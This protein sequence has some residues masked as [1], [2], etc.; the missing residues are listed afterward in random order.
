MRTRP[1]TAEQERDREVEIDRLW[2]R[3]NGTS[4]SKCAKEIGATTEEVRAV[5]LRHGFLRKEGPRSELRYMGRIGESDWWSI[6]PA[7]VRKIAGAVNLR[8]VTEQRRRNKQER[9]AGVYVVG[10]DEGPRRFK[11]GYASKVTERLAGLRGQS[12]IRLRL[13]AFIPNR[14][15]RM[16]FGLHRVFRAQRVHG[17]WFEESPALLWLCERYRYT[18]ES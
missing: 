10:T 7:A 11:I 4:F 17:E 14:T 3:Y 2:H 9:L 13:L 1:L 8:R 15:R 6:S 12:P 5:A 16:E 18:E